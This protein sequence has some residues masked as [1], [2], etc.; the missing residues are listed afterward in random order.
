MPSIP[1]FWDIGPH[2]ALSVESTWREFVCHSGNIVV[3][4]VIP[5]PRTFENA[6]FLFQEKGVVAE[7]KEVATEFGSSAAFI[8]GFDGLMSKVIAENPHWKPALLGG[9]APLPNWFNREFVRLFRPPISRILKK[10]NR[11]IR[12]TKLHFE[13][14]APT[15]VLLFVNDGFTAL[16]PEPV[17]ALAASLL[18][19]S[20]SSI[21]CFV[22]LTVNRYIAFPG[23]DIPRL[24]WAPVY[25]DRAPEWL[26]DF[27]NSLGSSWFTF[28]E[29]KIGP[30]TVPN[31][32]VDDA[33]ALHGSHPIV[34]PP[35]NDG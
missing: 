24:V 32:A 14:E 27:I 15:G 8:A 1:N 23:S 7:L 6:D 11:Q 21:D 35:S 17:R 31:I 28:L 2:T 13:I 33:D 29:S 26:V 10:A 19:N 34:P 20:Y 18:Q 3:E 12:E 16:G 22:Y 30:F 9:N 4:Q 5:N 25:S